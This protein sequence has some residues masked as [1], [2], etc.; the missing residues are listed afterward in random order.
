LRRHAFAPNVGR[1]AV[2]VAGDRIACW[3]DGAGRHESWRTRRAAGVG[4]VLRRAAALAVMARGVAVSRGPG[5]FSGPAAISSQPPVRSIRD[6]ADGG[7]VSRFQ[8]PTGSREHPNVRTSSTDS[9]PRR[10]W[11]A[12]K[13]RRAAQAVDAARRGSPRN[14]APAEA[15]AQP[16]S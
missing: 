6:D 8:D 16:A 5:T 14:S 10:A 4:R 7:I 9:S 2:G 1:L 13:R 15:E 12:A 3:R 11:P